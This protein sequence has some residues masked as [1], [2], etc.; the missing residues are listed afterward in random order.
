MTATVQGDDRDLRAFIS[1]MERR[2]LD[3]L[4]LLEASFARCLDALEA[5]LQPSR[6]HNGMIAYGHTR[7]TGGDER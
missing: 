2:L 7:R 5:A 1:G 4:D 3:R 6:S